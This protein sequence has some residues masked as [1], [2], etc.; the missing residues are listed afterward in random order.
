MAWFTANWF[1]VFIFIAFIAM[2]LFGHGGHGG[3]PPRPKEDRDNNDPTGR[4][5]N[6]RSRGQ[7]H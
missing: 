1:W 5:A 7:H 3:G 2:H 4:V 6:L